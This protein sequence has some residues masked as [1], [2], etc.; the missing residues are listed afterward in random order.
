MA[1]G[2]LRT[3]RDWDLPPGAKAQQVNGYDMAY[4]EKGSG[5][6]VVFVHG[7]SVDYRYFMAQMEPFALKYRAIAVSLRHY[8]PERWKDE[9]EF[10]LDQQVADLVR[11]LTTIFSSASSIRCAKLSEIPAIRCHA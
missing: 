5:T 8:Y 2:T 10:S 3:V 7:A 4:V 6:P 1:E 9:G 11:T